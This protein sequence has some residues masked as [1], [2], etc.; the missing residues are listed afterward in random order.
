MK[1]TQKL[2]LALARTKNARTKLRLAG[3][4]DDGVDHYD[5]ARH[6]D[7]AASLIERMLVRQK[8]SEQGASR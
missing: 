5:A 6:L 4:G 3:D 8:R 7:Q 1:R 2:E